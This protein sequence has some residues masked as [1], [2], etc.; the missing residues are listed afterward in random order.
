MPGTVIEI[1]S[2]RKLVGLF[3][4]LLLVQALFFLIGG[5]VAP[6]PSTAT[7]QTMK[8]CIGKGDKGEGV[9][10]PE[11]CQFMDDL[12]STRSHS[13]LPSDIVF[14]V[15]IP[16]KPFHMIPWFQYLL[17]LL[18]VKITFQSNHQYVPDASM[19][20]D[21]KI[22]YSDEDDAKVRHEPEA[23]HKLAGCLEDRVLECVFPDPLEEGYEY[24]CDPLHLFQLGS[25]S[26]KYYLVNIRL[27]IDVSDDSEDI[28]N[29][30]IGPVKDL[31]VVSI[32]QTGGFTKVWVSLK[33]VTSFIMVFP[34]V[35]FWRR[36]VALKRKPMLIEKAIFSLGI[37]LLFLNL[38]LELVSIFFDAPWMLF[39]IDV[40]QG[41]F[42]AVLLS[43][44]IIFTGE[45]LM[46]RPK[47]NNL[48]SYR[49]HL[50]IIFS[51]ML[52]LLAFDVAERGMQLVNPCNTVWQ[53]PNFAI[54]LLIIASVCGCVYFL[55][56][57]YLVFKVFRAISYKRR[58]AIPPERE[59][60]FRSIVYRFRTLMI[61]SVAT[62]GLTVT[63]YILS[64]KY[65]GLLQFGDHSIE[66]NSAFFTGVYGLWNIYVFLVLSVYAPSHKQ[67]DSDDADPTNRNEL[68]ALTDQTQILTLTQQKEQDD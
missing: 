26:H 14:S 51:S 18:T 12:Q 44:W 46:D 64:Q 2:T 55:M 21:V 67:F 29:K 19:K 5:L 31:G 36:I 40:R 13:F 52:A 57:C 47:R 15:V 16:R 8:N 56:L 24:D 66:V 58:F 48:S 61:L 20:L 10:V 53:R 54:A 35:W 43:F 42:Y 1:L 45:H 41:F 38:P 22:F 68:V 7:E 6:Q 34:L 49:C 37:S 9:Y 63:F 23:W 39:F 28:P 60:R 32:R 25:V 33:S 30:N 62:A 65:D 17:A 3:C 4:L 27:P 50:G 59:A 11:K